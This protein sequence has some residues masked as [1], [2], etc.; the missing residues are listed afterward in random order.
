MESR[1]LVVFN[2]VNEWLRFAEAKNAM[3][4]AL[5]GV[6]VFGVARLF[7]IDEIMENKI[8]CWYFIIHFLCLGASTLVALLSFIPQLKQITPKFNFK[9]QNDDFLYFACL[10]DKTVAEVTEVYRDKDEV[11]S[12]Y[13][14]HLANQIITNAGITKRK[15]DYFTF[16]CWLTIAAIFT[17][18]GAGF[19]ALFNYRNI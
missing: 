8:L 18:L 16:A 1:L 11:V 13:H 14:E 9:N 7:K 3:I 15:Y 4:I 5:N 12:V 10:K 19:Y 17:P 2:N 6:I